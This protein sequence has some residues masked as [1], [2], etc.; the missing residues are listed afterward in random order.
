MDALT[1]LINGAF[2]AFLWTMF[3]LLIFI[4]VAAWMF[5]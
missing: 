1:E 4:Q 5:G 2:V 3:A